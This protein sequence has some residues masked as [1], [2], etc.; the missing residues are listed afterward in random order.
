MMVLMKTHVELDEVLLKEVIALG[1]FRTKRAA[2]M[3]ALE[4]LA[5]RFSR[6]EL[7][8][9][10]GKVAWE[11]DLDERRASRPPAKPG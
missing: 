4:E 6:R 2:V 7:A 3:A 9:M 5:K 1:A 11:S 8:A 10:R